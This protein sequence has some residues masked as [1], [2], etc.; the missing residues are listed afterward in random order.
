MQIGE[1]HYL[2]PSADVP[3]ASPP[4]GIDVLLKTNAPP[5]FKRTVE[6]LSTP[7]FIFFWL[8]ITLSPVLAF[9]KQW[10][11]IL[12]RVERRTFGESG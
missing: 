6:S 1:T 7:L 12:P 4:P 2:Q 5:Q 3:S 9:T 11:L 8:R 10:R